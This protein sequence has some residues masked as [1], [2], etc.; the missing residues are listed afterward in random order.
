MGTTA[1]SG[2][3]RLCNAHDTHN[4]HGCKCFSTGEWRSFTLSNFELPRDLHLGA[5]PAEN[6]SYPICFQRPSWYCRPIIAFSFHSYYPWFI[7]DKRFLPFTGSTNCGYVLV[8]DVLLLEC[9]T[10]WWG[11]S[12]EA[13]FQSWKAKVRSWC[14]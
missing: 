6:N 8:F 4:R 14:H 13:N 3:N 10:G 9:F 12:L 11:L 5:P 2:H 7:A 1:S